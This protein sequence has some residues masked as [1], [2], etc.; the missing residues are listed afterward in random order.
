MDGPPARRHRRGLSGP[1]P[2]EVGANLELTSSESQLIFDILAWLLVGFPLLQ[3]EV[4]DLV[5]PS[6]RVSG[7]L[8]WSLFLTEHRRGVVG[9]VAI[10]ASC[11]PDIGAP[12]HTQVRH[13]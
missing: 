10:P 8:G 12:K 11:W 9:A 13:E 3:F 1:W 6:W 7:S 5:Q 4:A 2:E